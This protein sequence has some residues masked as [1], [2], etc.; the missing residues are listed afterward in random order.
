MNPIHVVACAL[1]VAASVASSPGPSRPTHPFATEVAR[2]ETYDCTL[3][4]ARLAQPNG[5]SR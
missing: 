5:R 1:L 4:I 3:A 2:V